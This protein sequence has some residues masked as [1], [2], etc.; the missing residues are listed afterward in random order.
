[1]LG[2]LGQGLA[3]QGLH[4]GLNKQHWQ[5]TNGHA[6][7]GKDRQGEAQVIQEALLSL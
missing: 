4:L 5:T 7:I 3:Y 2:K 1:M 6:L